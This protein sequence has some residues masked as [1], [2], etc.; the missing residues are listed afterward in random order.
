MP[1][2]LPALHVDVGN[3][4]TEDH[5]NR[6][7][8]A[9]RLA[10]T[11]AHRDT[12]DSFV[13]GLYGAWGEGK[14]TVLD[15][16]DEALSAEQ[17]VVLVRFNPWLFSTD[18]ALTQALIE[19]I[20]ISVELKMT[21]TVEG[22]KRFT[23]MALSYGG[24]LVKTFGGV[25]G[26]SWA[27]KGGELAE[28]FAD[29][30]NPQD[31]TV[32]QLKDRIGDELRR[33]NKK[34]VVLLDD[35][36]R[37]TRQ[38]VQQVFRLIKV[39][40]DF[41]MV[42]YVLAF[43]PEMVAA[44][45]AAQYGSG[46]REDGQRF[47]EKIVQLPLQL[48]HVDRPSITEYTFNRLTEVVE[49]AGITLT[50]G[51]TDRF[52]EVLREDIM[53][54]IRTPRQAK[55]Y[56]NAV[57]F[58]LPILKGETNPVDVLLVEAL[59]VLYPKTFELVR[60]HSELFLKPQG[61][62]LIRK[63]G[64]DLKSQWTA[65]LA[66]HDEHAISIVRDLFPAVSGIL[67]GM[68]VSRSGE[69]PRRQGV[70]QP[71]YFNRYFQYAISGDDVADAEITKFFDDVV[72]DPPAA[73]ALLASVGPEKRAFKFLEGVRDSI[74]TVPVLTQHAALLALARTVQTFE[75]DGF[76]GWLN[77]PVDTIV[78]LIRDLIEQGSVA[79]AQRLGLE[80]IDALPEG[81]ALRLLT[82]LEPGRRSRGMSADYDAHQGEIRRAL[83]E[84]VA[85][86]L[87]RLGDSLYEQLGR[88]YYR[89]LGWLARTRGQDVAEANLTRRFESGRDAVVEFLAARSPRSGEVYAPFH[90]EQENYL[91]L[92]KVI[93]IDRLLPYLDA[94]FPDGSS[95]SANLE[96]I[97]SIF[98]AE[99][100][101][102]TT[103]L[104]EAARQIASRI[105]AFRWLEL[106]QAASGD[107]V[108]PA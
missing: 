38:E 84:R 76:A 99:N 12:T 9:R 106:L 26:N 34:V 63:T 14:T 50:E 74:F 2:A 46:D 85:Q 61:S 96:A 37:L 78:R 79:E 88:D 57:A 69:D 98:E 44:A 87:E 25:T 60:S 30:M 39:A 42:T 73:D 45:V 36:D 103:D 104:E 54:A 3:R 29:G 65:M 18:E 40:A 35:I 58:A 68:H 48:P 77:N 1:D 90:F 10:Q 19:A 94:H 20:A 86:R 93:T 27:E 100:D 49:G 28:N 23:Q 47:L 62:G 6:K 13:I 55:R 101:V 107:G 7:P 97:T 71:R 16:M 75:R 21:D 24:K 70:H 41:P 43:D 91:A 15:Y 56:A 51:Q 52:I 83:E 59:R 102:A 5:F 32:H 72:S 8:F 11:I 31:Q 53:A 67:T 108:E 105:R 17:D 92:T 33:V 81:T 80:L 66:G 89:G 64:D 4:T 82:F 95:G 22:A